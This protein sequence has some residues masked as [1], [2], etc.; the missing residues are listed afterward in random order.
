MHGSCFVLT[1]TD[2]SPLGG[3][4]QHTRTHTASTA[5]RAQDHA[6]MYGG[7]VALRV[8]ARKYEFK[9]EVSV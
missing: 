3:R 9:D 2:P 7:L 6:R 4:G 5:M 1:A 8:L